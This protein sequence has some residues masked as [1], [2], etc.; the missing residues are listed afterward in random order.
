[1]NKIIIANGE[2]AVS[3]CSKWTK[4]DLDNRVIIDPYLNC[5]HYTI[6]KDSNRKIAIREHLF[7]EALAKCME[8]GFDITIP[9]DKFND[10]VKAV[11][12]EVEWHNLTENEFKY[13]VEMKDIVE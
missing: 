7:H 10:V 11:M 4:D 5:L 9:N 2:E 3:W 6:G 8:L 12:E 13:E 1:M